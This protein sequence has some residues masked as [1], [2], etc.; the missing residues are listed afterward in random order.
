MTS[1]GHLAI[2]QFKLFGQKLNLRNEI[3]FRRGEVKKGEL[4][5]VSSS[6]VPAY[7]VYLLPKERLVVEKIKALLT[8]RKSRDFFDLYY[9]LRS[10]ELRRALRLEKEQR[11]KILLG[12]EKEDPREIGKELK[13]LLP[14]DFWKLIKNLPEA[15]KN[16][17]G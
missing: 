5:L 15:I 14:I 3:S 8:R 9:I 11:E 7:N 17:L 1:G 16:Q 12:L 10:E 13:A 6:L 4:F 2:F